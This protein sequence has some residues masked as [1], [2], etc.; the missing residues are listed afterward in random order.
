MLDEWD[1]SV[2]RPTLIEKLSPRQLV[3]ISCVC[4]LSVVCAL[5]S[6]FLYGGGVEH[7]LLSWGPQ[8]DYYILSMCI[9][10]W[11]KYW[12]VVFIMVASITLKMIAKQVGWAICK[13]N[14]FDANRREIYGFRR[15]ELIIGTEILRTGENLV[16]VFSVVLLFAIYKFDIIIISVLVGTLISLVVVYYLLRKKTFYPHINTPPTD[17]HKGHIVETH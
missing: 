13:F 2:Q 5:F 14:V 1:D 12:S 9:D 4:M 3:A 11:P 17:H 8:P 7:H 6:V 10:T 15:S 16:D